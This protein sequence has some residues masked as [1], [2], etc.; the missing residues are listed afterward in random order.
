ML[1]NNVK[2]IYVDVDGVILN[3]VKAIVDIYNED[4]SCY[5][6]YKYVNW[7]GVDSWGFDELTFAS[8]EY[9]DQLFNQ[10]S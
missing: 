7:W 8:K 4:F 9:I 1:F 2:T 5:R 3:T 10:P 6:N